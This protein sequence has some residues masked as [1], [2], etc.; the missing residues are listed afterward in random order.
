MGISF[1]SALF[2]AAVKTQISIRKKSPNLTDLIDVVCLFLQF[3]IIA[4]LKQSFKIF[5]K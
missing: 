1:R 2:K 4:R 5:S 3:L